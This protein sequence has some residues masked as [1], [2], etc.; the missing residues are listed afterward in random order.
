MNFPCWNPFGN[1][2][3]RG[4][5]SPRFQDYARCEKSASAD[6]RSCA[7]LYRF[8]DEAEGRVRPIVITGANVTALRE[9]GAVPDDHWR[10]IVNPAVLTQ[11]RVLADGQHPRMF[12]AHSRLD[13]CA[14]S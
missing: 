6:P 11:P 3:S 7:D 8:D 10:E 12:D 4:G 1:N 9:T 14:G 5:N 13:D 2:A